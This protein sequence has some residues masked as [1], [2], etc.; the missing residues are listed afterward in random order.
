MMGSKGAMR[1]EKRVRYAR[2][3]VIGRDR[4]EKAEMYQ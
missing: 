3:R 4:R 1:A 2:S